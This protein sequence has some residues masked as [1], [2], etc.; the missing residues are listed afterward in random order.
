MKKMMI[1]KA[2]Q[3]GCNIDYSECPPFYSIIEYY[4]EDGFII[5]SFDLNKSSDYGLNAELDDASIE[6]IEETKKISFEFNID[7]PLYL[8]LL[9]LCQGD[10]I[11]EDDD[12]RLH[13]KYLRI[14]R[15]D[16][17]VYMDFVNE[18]N[19][20]DVINKFRIFIKNIKYDGRSKIDQQ[21]L[22]TKDRLAFFFAEASNNILN[23]YHQ[24]TLEEYLLEKQGYIEDEEVLKYVKKYHKSEW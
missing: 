7:H 12:T 19:D 18:K 24:M 3:L 6:E 5:K 23:E 15:K 21:Q 1:N 2:R 13:N 11:I 17:K 22:D 10:L 4:F 9:H 8:P 14:Y 20:A 16:N